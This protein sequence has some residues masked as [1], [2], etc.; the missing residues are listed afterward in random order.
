[1]ADVEALLGA[2]TLE[3]KAALTAGEG[4]FHTPGVERLGLPGIQF[5]DGPSGARGLSY[6]GLGGPASTCIPC[7]SAIGATWDASAACR[8]APPATPG[9]RTA[10]RSGALPSL[11]SGPY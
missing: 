3:E 9:T 10:R 7:G 6:P 2:L 8:W 11:L 4:M 5:T 1:M